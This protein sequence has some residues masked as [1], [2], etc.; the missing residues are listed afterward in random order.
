MFLIDNDDSESFERG[1]DRGSGSDGDGHFSLPDFSPLVKP[2]S[3][4]Q[5]AMKQGKVVPESILKS[6]EKLRSEENLWNEDDCFPALSQYLFNRAQVDLRLPAGGDSMD[7][8][9]GKSLRTDPFQDLGK[10]DFLIR[11]K[12]PHDPGGG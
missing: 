3:F 4:P 2:L 5:S 1:E 12:R 9:R 6:G 7:Q 8:E 11:W 10:N